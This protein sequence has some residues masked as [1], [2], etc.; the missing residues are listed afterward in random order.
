MAQRN[1][2]GVTGEPPRSIGGSG[3]GCQGRG[4]LGNCSDVRRRDG[5]WRGWIVGLGTFLQVGSCR[6]WPGSPDKEPGWSALGPLSPLRTGTAD[7]GQQ[8]PAHHRRGRRNA[9]PVV[10]RAGPGLGDEADGFSSG[11]KRSTRRVEHPH[12]ASLPRLRLAYSPG[13]RLV[14]LPRCFTRR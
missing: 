14:L 8:K 10:V 12:G 6:I 5:V 7:E 11:R 9:P 1:G 2:G 4:C 3:G 13:C